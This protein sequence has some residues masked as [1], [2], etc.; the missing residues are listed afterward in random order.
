MESAFGHDFSSVKVHT[1]S[2][3]AGLSNSLNARAFT[4]GRDIA[5]GAGEYQPGTLAGD[6][7]VAHE[8]AHVVQQH[9][10]VPSPAPLTVSQP[11]SEIEHDADEAAVGAMT[12]LWSSDPRLKKKQSAG[13]KQRS[14][15]QLQRCASS[16]P[17]QAQV[18][19]LPTGPV[20]EQGPVRPMKPSQDPEI[21]TVTP[22]AIQDC[23]NVVWP[24][25]Y[26][27]PNPAA[28]SGWIIQHIVL[29]RKESTKDKKSS[30]PP[31]HKEY[32]EAFNPRVEQGGQQSGTG[33]YDDQFDSYSTERTTSGSTTWLGRVKFYEGTLPSNFVRTNTPPAGTLPWTTE[34][35]NWWDD[36]GT[37]HNLWVTWDCTGAPSKPVMK[38]Q[39]G[40][41]IET[42]E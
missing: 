26:H 36:T 10:A 17:V 7:L 2:R 24:V 42:M 11:Q 16:P 39:R 12:A 4:I 8:L 32:W 29:D 15:L 31:V 21:N 33:A 25:K 22:Y 1:G 3:A 34:P 19:K 23:G 14:G 35:P 30:L 13:P 40:N 41:K 27:L 18:P 20:S 6:A 37:D 38:M 5:F 28:T 9:G